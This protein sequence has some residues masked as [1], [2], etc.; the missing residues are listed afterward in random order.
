M[1]EHRARFA[2]QRRFVAQ[3]LD[4]RGLTFI[5]RTFA[6]G[7]EGAPYAPEVVGGQRHRPAHSPSSPPSF[8][9]RKARAVRHPRSTVAVPTSI[10]SAVSGI[11]RPL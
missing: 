1:S 5:G 11:V 2:E 4:Q 8:A 10:S 6:G 7:L 3:C 9:A